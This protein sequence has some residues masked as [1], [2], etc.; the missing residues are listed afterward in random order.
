MG[1]LLFIYSRTLVRAAKLNAQRHREADGGQIDWRIE[2]K[3]RHGQLEK[4]E[5]G[6]LTQALGQ[7]FIGKGGLAKPSK[8][9]DTTVDVVERDGERGR[10]LEEA[11]TRKR[12]SREG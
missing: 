6:T 10:A 3:R 8:E 2:S 12:L 9:A 11:K 5:G 1:G 4:V 7:Q